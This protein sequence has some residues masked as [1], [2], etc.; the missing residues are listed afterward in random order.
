MPAMPPEFNVDQQMFLEDRQEGKAWSWSAIRPSVVC[1]FAL[2]NPM[3]LAMVIAIYAAISKESGC[4][5]ASRA[6]PAP[7][8]ACSR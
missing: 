3:N 6:G 8:T 2:G 5:C 4:L 7:T 1:G